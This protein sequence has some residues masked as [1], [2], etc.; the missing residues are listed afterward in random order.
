MTSKKY[1]TKGDGGLFKRK[2]NGMWIGVVEVPG[3][4]GKRRQR[5]VSSKDRNVAIAKL[6][7]LRAEVDAGR[8]PVT[9]KT[10]V[11]AWLDRWIEDIRGPKLRPGTKD[12]Y[13]RTIR[14]HIIPH[15]GTKRLDR[16][17]PQHVRDMQTAIPHSRTSQLAHVILR[18]ALDDAVKEGL[19]SPAIP[20][21][22][23][24]PSPRTRPSRYCARPSTLRTRW[25][26][27]G[28]RRSSW[29]RARG[30]SSG[31]SGRG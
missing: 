26:P 3:T 16:L 12:D 1:R 27:A 8:I 23:V 13:A 4:D 17:T 18:S 11:K 9:G 20:P 31:C 7:K 15:I 21:P 5:S 28:P 30:R 29:A 22:T 2:D 6:K 19:L 14:L 25:R 24:N 10:T